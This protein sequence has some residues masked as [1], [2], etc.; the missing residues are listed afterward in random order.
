M[1]NKSIALVLLCV[2][3]MDRNKTPQTDGLVQMV[4]WASLI[5][6]ELSGPPYLEGWKSIQLL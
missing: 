6:G 4:L 5:E 3:Q 1:P 2:V